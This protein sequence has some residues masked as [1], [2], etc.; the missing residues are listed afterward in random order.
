[1]ICFAQESWVETGQ[2]PIF[3]SSGHPA[4]LRADGSFSQLWPPGMGQES[5]A[6]LLLLG[7]WYVLSAGDLRRLLWLGLE[8][9]FVDLC[10]EGVVPSE[11]V[12]SGEGL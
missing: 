9:T 12:F 8:M 10:V 11:A 3:L 4:E 7:K 6:Q 2:S 5:K 1:M